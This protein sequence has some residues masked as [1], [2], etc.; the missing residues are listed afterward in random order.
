MPNNSE[1][2]VYSVPQVQQLLRISRSSV[3]EAIRRHELPVLK[4]GKRLL[5]PRAALEHI[6]AQAGAMPGTSDKG[7][8][9]DTRQRRDD[10]P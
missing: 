6:I 5:I 2:L 10:E 7:G 1:S 3:Y 4:I 8:A 9:H